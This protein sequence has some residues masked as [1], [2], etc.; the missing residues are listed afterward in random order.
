MLLQISILIDKMKE[1]CSSNSFLTLEAVRKVPRNG[2]D[3]NRMSITPA[4]DSINQ[5]EIL[6]RGICVKRSSIHRK[7]RQKLFPFN[8]G[9]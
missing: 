6:S 4:P 8:A 3:S 2:P 1:M 7:N 5:H 9:T